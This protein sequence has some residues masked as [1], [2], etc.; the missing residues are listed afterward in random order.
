MTV[1]DIQ[2]FM[3]IDLRVGRV[4][5]AEPV[6]G[7]NKLILMKVDIGTEI[8]QVVAG[9]AKTYAPESLV[10]RNVVMV[11]NLQPARLMGYESQGMVLAADVDGRPYLVE[12]PQDIPPGSRVR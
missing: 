2:Q 5:S 9:I 12:V 1:I 6:Q 4:I 10:N 7:S 8:R 11:A 3:T